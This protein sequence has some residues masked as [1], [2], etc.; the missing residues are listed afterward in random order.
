MG[1]QL[2]VSDRYTVYFWNDYHTITESAAPTHP[3]DGIWGLSPLTSGGDAYVV[4]SDTSGRIWIYSRFSGLKIFQAPLTSTSAPIKTFSPPAYYKD[5][6]GAVVALPAGTFDV[7]GDFLPIG[8]GDR[9][10]VE[11]AGH[12]RVMRVVN[13]D[14]RRR[15]P[16]SRRTST[17]SSAKTA[18]KARAA[19]R[20]VGTSGLAGTPCAQEDAFSIDP[21]G[22]LYI[23]DNATG[24]S[25]RRLDASLAVECRHDSG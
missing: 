1:N 16:S 9:V 24:G 21:Q 11:D 22:N 7:L 20:A 8:S 5:A 18:S 3:P 10:W 25:G 6:S 19:T 14:G 13:F 15:C 23:Q 12:S 17:S 2:L 4:K